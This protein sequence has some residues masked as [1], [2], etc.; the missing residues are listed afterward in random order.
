MTNLD[1]ER[2]EID[3]KDLCECCHLPAGN[4]VRRFGLCSGTNQV[5]DFGAG[6]P[7]Y[8]LFMKF[9]WIGFL[10]LFLLVGLPN[11]VFNCH[12]GEYL[13]AWLPDQQSGQAYPTYCTLGSY[14]KNPEQ[15]ALYPYYPT[16]GAILH[17]VAIFCMYIYVIIL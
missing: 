6:F 9:T 12:G 13:K 7:L 3:P 17:H 15:Y 2:K 8:F 16:I 11:M 1:G 10:L 14:G 4:A 5:K